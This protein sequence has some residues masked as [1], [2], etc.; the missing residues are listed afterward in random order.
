[1]RA[2]RSTLHVAAAVLTVG[3]LIL[4]VAPPSTSIPEGGVP[5][6]SAPASWAQPSPVSSDSLAEEI[7]LSNVFSPSRTAPLRRFMPPDLAADSV[8]GMLPDTALISSSDTLPGAAGPV[9]AL[10]GTVVGGGADITRALLHLDA[11][12]P[13]PRLYAVGER[14]GG[15]RVVAITPREVTLSG[16][17]GR[18]VLRLQQKEERP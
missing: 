9:P 4:A 15:Y 16:P 18:V 14:A 13:G 1:M 2:L 12:L 6:L 17:N 8:N 5:I 7:V 11:S 3:G 10:F